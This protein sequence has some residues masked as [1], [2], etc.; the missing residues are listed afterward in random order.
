AAFSGFGDSSI[1]S[2]SCA[3][4]TSSGSA[5]GGACSGGDSG[6][7]GLAD[8][9]TY[10]PA[11]PGPW[12]DGGSSFPGIA[13]GEIA[14]RRFIVVRAA[15]RNLDAAPFPASFPFDEI[16][17]ALFVMFFFTRLAADAFTAETRAAAA[18]PTPS[19]SD[20]AFLAGGAPFLPG[21]SAGAP[22]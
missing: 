2:A 22:G 13:F 21:A 3:T 6:S 17:S 7:G 10:L 16:S 20:S 15:S 11:C 12:G 14:V 1:F 5:A 18:A 9:L 19:E 4:F 8:G